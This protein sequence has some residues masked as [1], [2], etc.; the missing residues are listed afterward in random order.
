[1]C[2]RDSP[3]CLRVFDTAALKAVSNVTTVA[4]GFIAFSIGGEFKAESL[5]RVGMDALIITVFQAFLAVI[6]V[7]ITLI[8]FGFD[9]PLALTLGAIA[10]AT[11]PAATLMVVRQYKAQGSLTNTLLSV[12]AMRC[13]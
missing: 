12:V 13:V 10:T 8:L 2:I 11:A 9:L 4:L 3:Y 5:K 1:M 7:D 6:L